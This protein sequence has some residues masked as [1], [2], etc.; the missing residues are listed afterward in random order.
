MFGLYNIRTRLLQPYARLS[1]SM[2]NLIVFTIITAMLGLNAVYMAERF[3]KDQP[4]TYISRKATR[5]GYMQAFRPEYAAFQYANEHLDE[6]S[7]LFGWEQVNRGADRRRA[8][9]KQTPFD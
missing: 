6:T 8:P 1:G 5:D 7:H 9:I 4:L 3:Q 2:K